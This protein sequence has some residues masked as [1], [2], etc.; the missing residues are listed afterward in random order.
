[1]QNAAIS[2]Y[3]L[4]HSGNTCARHFK[5]GRK[6]VTPLKAEDLLPAFFAPSARLSGSIAILGRLGIPSFG[7]DPAA[8]LRSA[9]KGPYQ[10]RLY[11]MNATA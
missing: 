7:A 4:A 9:G 10:H 8:G 5:V 3:C 1:M 6:R 2:K 11:F